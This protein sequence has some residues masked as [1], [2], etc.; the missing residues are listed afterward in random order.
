MT[1]KID[2][3]SIINIA[4]LPIY[5]SRMIEILWQNGNITCG[6]QSFNM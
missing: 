2:R 4:E 5:F 6:N 1:E 3:N